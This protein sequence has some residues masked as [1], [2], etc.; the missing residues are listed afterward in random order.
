MAASS[1]W[2]TGGRVWVLINKQWTPATITSVTSAEVTFA[3][4]YGEQC[5][6]PRSSLSHDNC[7]NMHQS[8]IDSVQDMATLG[9]LHESAILY[10]IFQRYENDIIYTYIGSI[11]S[12]VNPY[13]LIDGIYGLEIMQSYM[14]KQLGDLP[15]H[16]YAIANEIYESMWRKRENQCVLISG[17]SGAGKTE[18]TKFILSYLSAMSQQACPSAAGR[19][20]VEEAIL[21]SS[22][23]LEAFGNAKTVYNNNSSRFGKF[24]LLQFAETGNIIGGKIT[25]YLLEKNRVVSQ[26]PKERNFHIF[27]ALLAGISEADKETMMLSTPESYHYLNQSGCVSDPTINDASDFLRV[28]EAFDIMKVPAESFQYLLSVLAGILNIGNI[29]FSTAGGAQVSDKSVLQVAAKCLSLDAF[30]L[31]DAL[32]QKFMKLRGEE[33]TTPLTLEQAVDSRDSLSMALYANTFRWILERINARIIGKKHF[34]TVGVLD[35][36]GFENFE[37]NRFEQFNINFANEKLQEY[38][39]KHIFSLEQHEYSKEG[40]DWADIDWVDNAE[41]LNLIEKKLGV[42]SLL[43]EESR[44]PKG[45]DKSLLEK[46]H[47][48]HKDNPFYI[49]PKVNNMKFGIRHYAGD[50]FYEIA[51]ILEKNRD[52]FR[53]DMLKVLK[54]TKSD[55]VYDL[56]AHMTLDEEGGAS[57]G[58]AFKMDRR[59]GGA[60]KKATVSSQF[61]TSLHSLMT[62]LGQANPYF[63]RCIKP[64][65]I[66]VADNFQPQLVQNQLKYSGMMETVRIRRQGYPVRRIFEDFLFRYEVLGRNL[67]LAGKEPPVCC[68]LILNYEDSKGKDWQIG[69]TKVFYRE[70]L[71]RHLERRRDTELRAVYIIIY[72]VVLTVLTRYVASS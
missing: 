19:Y 59:G 65:A 42:L 52:S 5:T 49:K 12:A 14:R 20:A 38:F 58:R 71:E 40:I 55:F 25:D 69:K 61:K 27:Y 70:N 31:G 7:T 13:K 11:L 45:T 68:K 35:I 22:P 60:K 36:F 1:V 2:H 24:I 37:V 30:R 72:S 4:A 15:P 48:S 41:C 10:N 17:E 29:T 26:N 66:K 62:E 28:K 18:S 8:S 44:F 33:I 43:D 23:I 16:I 39:N 64:N 9:D 50:V 21:Q 63:V 34:A 51:G 57:G 54:D 6:L 3:G 46:L 47:G 67:G 56:F 53:D 32:T